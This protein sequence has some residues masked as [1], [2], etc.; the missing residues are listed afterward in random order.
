MALMDGRMDEQ[1]GCCFTGHRTIPDGRAAEL[2]ERLINGVQYVYTTYGITDFYTGG[3]LGFDTLAAEA[4]VACRQLYPEIRLILAIPCRDQANRW[5]AADIAKYEG[6]KR[7][8]DHVVYLSEQYS[9]D[10]MMIRNRFMVDHSRVC[11]CY[12]TKKTGGT[13]Y[14]INY[15]RH[16]ELRIFNLA[17]PKGRTK[18]HEN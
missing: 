14:T 5:S 15:A 17:M 1:K 11:I 3:A 6:I 2:R 13:A 10:C 9:R 12:L 4:V 7:K 16:T 8:A 18:K